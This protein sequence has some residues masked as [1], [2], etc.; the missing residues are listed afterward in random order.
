MSIAQNNSGVAFVFVNPDGKTMTG[1]Y[2][3]G[4]TNPNGFGI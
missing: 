2:M 3:R 1:E 4:C